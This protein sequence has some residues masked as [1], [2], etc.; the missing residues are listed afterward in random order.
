MFGLPSGGPHVIIWGTAR[1]RRSVAYLAVVPIAIFETGQ[2]T[3]YFTGLNAGRT[4]TW[5]QNESDAKPIIRNG[6]MGD[7]SVTLCRDL[8][9]WLMIW[10]SRPP[11]PRG[12]LFSYSRTP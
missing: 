5:S 9:L 10:N 1:Y 3:L 8:A 6:K 7:I 2:G 4:P 12:I 11:A